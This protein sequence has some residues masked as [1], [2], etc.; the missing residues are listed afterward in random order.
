MNETTYKT[1]YSFFPYIYPNKKNNNIKTLN[2]KLSLSQHNF[3]SRNKKLIFNAI[4]NTKKIES[5]KSLK[6]SIN[7]NMK[8][9]KFQFSPKNS[10]KYFIH[11]NFDISK[12]NKNFNSSIFNIN[13]SSDKNSTIFNK[14]NSFS[15][16]D[17]INNSTTKNTNALILDLNKSDSFKNY[18]SSYLF[19][20]LLKKISLEQKKD[21]KVKVYKNTVYKLSKFF[22]KSKDKKISARQ[23][24]KHYL[25]EAKK[26]PNNKEHVFSG[27]YDYSYVICPQLKNLYGNEDPSFINKINEIKK[28][29]HIA[30]KKDFD[31][32]E[33]Q[34]TLM[35]LFEKRI[36]KKNMDILRNNYKLFNQ[37]HFRIDKDIPK[38]KYINLALKLRE[39]V[40][41]FA[42]KNIIKMDKNYLNYFNKEKNSNKVKKDKN[43]KTRLN[44]KNILPIKKINL[45]KGK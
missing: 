16:I 40:S 36:S 33:Y 5:I 12:F 25:K 43:A 20:N 13:N 2:Q 1:F 34:K 9:D 7:K 24:Y 4:E 23:I 3:S 41:D 22:K 21:I 19:A 17:N 15:S 6:S 30:K 32:R 38:G 35:K 8:K 10:N 45:R 11:N 14:E 39:H 18:N 29:D 42:F 26:A 31:I 37:K 28:N 27:S 44:N